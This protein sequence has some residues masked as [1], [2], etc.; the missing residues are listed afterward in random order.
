VIVLV[1]SPVGSVAIV[2]T[3]MCLVQ[4]IGVHGH[5]VGARQDRLDPPDADWFAVIVTF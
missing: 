4:P 1:V 5:G 3:A 2:W